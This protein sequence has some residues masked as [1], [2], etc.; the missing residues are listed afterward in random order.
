MS[1]FTRGY[2]PLLWRTSIATAAPFRW[3]PMPPMSWRGT[4]TSCGCSANTCSEWCLGDLKIWL[5]NVND[6]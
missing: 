2:Q 4:G 6:G 1:T 3:S 5:M